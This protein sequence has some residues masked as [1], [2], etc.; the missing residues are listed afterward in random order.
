MLL[1]Q[2][3]E[4]NVHFR[5]VASAT[6]DMDFLAI[7]INQCPIGIGNEA[8]NFFAG[9]AKCKATTMASPAH[10]SNIYVHQSLDN[11]ENSNHVMG[12]GYKHRLNFQGEEVQNTKRNLLSM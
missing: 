2:V 6:M 9:T 10:L 5:F 1:K 12:L 4:I 8:P 3:T 7:D 11:F